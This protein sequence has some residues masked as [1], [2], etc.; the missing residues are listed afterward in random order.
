MF[1]VYLVKA[2]A[3]DPQSVVIMSQLRGEYCVHRVAVGDIMARGAGY[4]PPSGAP[5]RDSLEVRTAAQ[6]A[7]NEGY[8]YGGQYF[9]RASF[10]DEN[11]ACAAAY[12]AFRARADAA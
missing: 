5:F 6:A 10:P 12:A 7:A 11:A 9:P 1:E 2:M 8:A 4:V 3:S